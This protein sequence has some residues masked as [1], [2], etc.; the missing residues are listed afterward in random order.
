MTAMSRVGLRHVVRSAASVVLALA[1]AASA[2][3]LAKIDRTI[4]KAPKYHAAKQYYALLALGPESEKRVWFVID[5]NDL[6]VDANGDGDLTQP[7]ERCS[8]PFLG[9]QEGFIPRWREW[10]LPKLALSERCTGV[11]VHFAELNTAWRP[12]ADAGNRTE[13]ERVMAV[14]AT[15]PDVNITTIEVGVPGSATQ[16]CNAMFSTSAAT[17]PVFRMDASLTVGVVEWIA[18]RV[19]GR[20][21]HDETL[22]VA[23][24]AK[25]LGGAQAGCFSYLMYKGLPAD[26]RPVA[27]VE[28]PAADGKR[29]PSR[30]F[31]LRDKC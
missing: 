5:G 3:D 12:A 20:T 10:R 29:L 21:P 6:Y 17:A 19:L 14:V 9:R 11:T 8:T 22:Q 4:A 31:E 28:F 15:T 27:D 30:R 1:A 7:G 24:G 23:V 2:D 18:P 13:M 25:G 26:A 16:F